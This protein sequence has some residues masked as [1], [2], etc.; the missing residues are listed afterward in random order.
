MNTL[1][2]ILNVVACALN[3]LMGTGRRGCSFDFK[4]AAVAVFLVKGTRILTT[5]TP[6]LAYF[7]GLAKKGKAVICNGIVNFENETPDNDMGTRSNS[8]EMYL[9]LKHPYKWKLMFDSGIN[10][11]KALMQLESNRAYDIILFDSK[12]D[13]LLAKNSDGSARGLDLGLLSTGAYIMGNDNSISLTVQVNREDFDRN[14]SY[15]ES[16]NLDFQNRDLE[17]FDDVIFEFAP[18]AVGATKLILSAKLNDGSH[19]AEGLLNTNVRVKKNGTVLT[20]SA[21]NFV[22]NE[23]DK[24]YEITVPATVLAET[25]SAETY[26]STDN[27]RVVLSPLGYMSKSN[28]AT[29]IVA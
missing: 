1:K 15:I 7:R 12:G 10:Y 6:N 2:M 9:M 21:P 23:A 24:T 26:D 25:Y 4:S 22:A 14:V 11:A 27:T 18:V 19:F 3:E 8:G 28:V 13:M 5:E 29:V 20:I 16:K 17:G